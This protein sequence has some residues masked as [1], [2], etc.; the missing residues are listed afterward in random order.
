MASAAKRFY[1][2]PKDFLLLVAGLIWLAAGFNILRIGLL[3]ADRPWSLPGAAASLAV[4]AAFFFLI[5][6]RMIGKHARRISGYRDD[7]VHI[8]LFFDA[9]SYCIMAFMMTFGILLRHSNWWPG[10]CIRDFY[11][12][13]GAALMGAGVG[14]LICFFKR[15]RKARKADEPFELEVERREDETAAEPQVDGAADADGE[16]EEKED[17]TEE[18]T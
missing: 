3:A 18:D 17:E 7:R 2:I 8:L 14:F 4:F 16:M 10:H 12:G 6:R 13:L 9:K 15:V 11:T 1:H 5:F